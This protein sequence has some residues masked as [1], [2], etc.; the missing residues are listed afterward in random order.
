[1]VQD[2]EDIMKR[3]RKQCEG[4]KIYLKIGKKVRRKIS[5]EN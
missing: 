3:Y 4:L 2:C 1:M 5:G